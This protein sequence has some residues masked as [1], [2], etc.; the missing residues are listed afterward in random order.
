MSQQSHLM[1]TLSLPCH[2]LMP[3]MRPDSVSGDYIDQ[4]TQQ[5]IMAHMITHH[6]LYL[7]HI[8]V[9]YVQTLL[10]PDEYRATRLQSC[11]NGG[12]SF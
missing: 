2:V 10:C 9:A 6:V 8:L 1:W 5:A 12:H 3:H 4:L 11:I 7:S